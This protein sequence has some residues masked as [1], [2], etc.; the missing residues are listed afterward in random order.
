MATRAEWARRVERWQRSG[1]TAA[2]FGRREGFDGKQLSWWKWELSRNATR[3]R[4]TVDNNG[5]QTQALEVV[6]VHV[7]PSTQPTSG[8]IEVLVGEYLVRI[9]KGF[10]KAT[11]AGVLDVLE[12]EDDA[13]C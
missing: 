7:V 10:D 2:E 5:S 6:A 8:N 3:E 12:G 4:R 9:P 11:L 13:A 1:L